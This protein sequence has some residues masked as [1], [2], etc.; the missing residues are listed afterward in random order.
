MVIL[1]LRQSTLSKNLV[2]RNIRLVFLNLYWTS[3]V[4]SLICII[5]NLNSQN[6]RGRRVDD[7]PSESEII[8]NGWTAAVEGA[9]HWKP[10]IEY[11]KK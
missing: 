8:C 9:W 11:A 3:V 5:P 6:G 10:P 2:Q 7:I 4:S 1:E